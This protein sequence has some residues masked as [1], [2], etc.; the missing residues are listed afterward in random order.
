MKRFVRLSLLLLVTFIGAVECFAQSSGRPGRDGEVRKGV[1]GD[2]LDNWKEFISEEGRFS[3]LLPGTPK[4]V[5]HEIDSP[6]GKSRGHYFNLTTFADFGF[7]YTQFPLAVENPELAKRLLDR[8]RDGLLATL[9]GKLSEEKEISLDGHPGRFIKAELAS[10][11][12]YRHK[13]FIVGSRSYQIVFISRDKGAPPAVLSYHD[14]AAKKFLDSFKL[15]QLARVT[16]ESR[17]YR[18]RFGV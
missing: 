15:L 6:F 5:V 1:A 4:E 13:V 10:G 11:D 12:T 14:S 8:A 9:E 16:P 7:S 2:G 3:V 18:E 17:S